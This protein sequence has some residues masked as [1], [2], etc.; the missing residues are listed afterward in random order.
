MYAA[1]Q[2]WYQEFQSD[3][4]AV[5]VVLKGWLDLVEVRDIVA[6]LG[7]E[8]WSKFDPEDISSG[9]LDALAKEQAQLVS[10]KESAGNAKN[11]HNVAGMQVAE[12]DVEA[13][14]RRIVSQLTRVQ[15]LG[16]KDILDR[17]M[18]IKSDNWT[19]FKA[20]ALRHEYRKVVDSFST[21]GWKCLSGHRYVADNG[22][23]QPQ[24]PEFYTTHQS[25]ASKQTCLQICNSVQGCVAMSM[26]KG[27]STLGVY[28]WFCDYYFQ[29]PQPEAAGDA[30]A[31]SRITAPPDRRGYSCQ[32]GRFFVGSMAGVK[33]EWHD[34]PDPALPKCQALC[35][36]RS[37][38][39]VVL[40]D[41]SW[42]P[43]NTCWL[44]ELFR[45]ELYLS[46]GLSCTR[47]APRGYVCTADVNNPGGDFANSPRKAWSDQECADL[48]SQQAGCDTFVVRETDC[49]LK[50]GRP[51]SKA[52]I[53]F[54]S[55]SK[56]DSAPLAFIAGQSPKSPSSELEHADKTVAAAVRNMTVLFAGHDWP[57]QVQENVA[58][59]VPW[60]LGLLGAI[61]A[62]TYATAQR[63]WIPRLSA[64]LL[65]SE[66]SPPQPV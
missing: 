26:W 36:A 4:T 18:E 1:F 56:I 7:K 28:T 29:E 6:G 38:C 45:T 33:E 59:T 19:W 66:F 23:K 2:D 46:T 31:C 30:V 39:N 25:E 35:D 41:W 27:K 15:A 37:W 14:Q 8:V 32:Y 49:W 3:A 63:Q 43:N 40:L 61:L 48:C 53:G 55:C 34:L 60:L 20:E 10:L 47:G 42:N 16:E 22:T 21:Y 62:V 51:A 50:K 24:R 9:T 52:A 13:L 44:G 11:S 5:S 12:Q 64:P 57:V 58:I 54:R 17:Q 65:G